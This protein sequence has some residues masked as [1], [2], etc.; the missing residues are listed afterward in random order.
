M[1]AEDQAINLEVIKNQI[2]KLGLAYKTTYSN[3]GQD[4]IDKVK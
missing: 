3:N 2:S 1:V 4:L